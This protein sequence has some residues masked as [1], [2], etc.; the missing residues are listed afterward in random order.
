MSAI[1]QL[2]GS[3]LVDAAGSKHATSSKLADCDAVAIY[4]S[5]HWCP[6][7]RGFT[8]KL[9]DI[10][11]GL[12]ASGKKFEVVFA[13]SDS[14]QAAFD[15]YLGE[16]P[17]LA[18]P[19]SA[20]QEKEALSKKFKVSGIPTLVIVDGKTGEL[21]T[22]DGRSAITED[23]TGEAFPWKPKAFADVI[24]SI[25]HLQTST[26]EL[27]E[28]A[29]ALEGKT[30]GLYFSAHWCGPCRG[31]TPELAKTYTAMKA[32]GNTDFE[33]IFVS[34]DRDQEAFDSYHKEMPWLAL[35]FSERAVKADL[36]KCCDV[37][38]IPT[39][40]IVGSDG[41]IINKDGRSALGKD[42]T[43]ANFPWLPPAYTQLEDSSSI[44]DTPTLIAFVEG[45]SAEVRTEVEAAMKLVAEAAKAAAAEGD[46]AAP[47]MAFTVA[48]P[49]D[50]LADRVRDL[51]GVGGPTETPLLMLVDLA[52]DKSFYTCT[53]VESYDAAA[54]SAFVD[55]YLAKAL[56]KQTLKF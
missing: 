53:G 52:D 40:V 8:P 42:P 48:Q 26:G 38:G 6:P 23:P 11:K 5:A 31:F 7:C 10:Y 19:Y 14:D 20:R 21:I 37:E 29:A 35:P 47:E 30:Y 25:T 13:S 32:A 49:N 34:S 50:G 15:S 33:I 12:K 39:L 45:A 24:G 54:I 27:V 51:A 41:T 55:G 22:T 17:W 9:A 43:G 36:S 44:N 1:E 56:E 18:L 28:R 46:A 4:F 16:M 2:L 3:E